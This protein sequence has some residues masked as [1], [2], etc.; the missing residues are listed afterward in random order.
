[1]TKQKAVYRRED[2]THGSEKKLPMG[3][4]MI[5]GNYVKKVFITWIKL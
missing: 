2:E 4:L 3:I 1:M 5:L